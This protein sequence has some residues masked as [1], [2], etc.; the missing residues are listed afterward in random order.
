MT[1]VIILKEMQSKRLKP[2]LSSYNKVLATCAKSGYM[3][4]EM[5]IFNSMISEVITPD[6]YSYGNVI[7]WSS[8]SGKWQEAL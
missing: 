1:A 4:A 3:K 7:H 6:I 5:E 2:E 8:K